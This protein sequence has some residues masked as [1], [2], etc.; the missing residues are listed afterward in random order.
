MPTSRCSKTRLVV[1]E[2]VLDRVLDRDDVAVEVLVDPVEHRRHGR[3]LARAGGAADEQDA[4]LGL[5]QLDEGLGRCKLQ[6]LERRRP[7][8]DVPEDDAD[9]AALVEGVDAEAADVL[10]GVGIVDLP[11][12]LPRRLKMPR[13]DAST[14]A[15]ACR[16]RR[17]D[18]CRPA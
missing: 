8:L 2:R 3:A 9:R 4:V 17:S 18:P 13:H 16:R 15:C 6:I 7:A 14:K 11:V 5:R 10:R 1:G 12:A